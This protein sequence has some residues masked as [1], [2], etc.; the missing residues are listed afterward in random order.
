MILKSYDLKN[1]LKKKV[2]LY[3]L[4]GQN[5]DLINEVIEKNLKPLTSKNQY[6]YEES[7]ILLNKENFEESLTSKSFFEEDKLLIINRATDKILEIV[8]QIYKNQDDDLKIILKSGVL[9]KKSKLRIFFE[10][11]KDIIVIPFYED[12]KQSLQFIAQNFVREYNI[13]ISPQNINFIVEKSKGSRISLKSELEKIK[14][15]SKGKK[16]VEF[17]D[18]LKLTCSAKD[19]EISELADECLAKNKK[20]TISMLNEFNASIE[21]NILILKSFLYKLKRLKRLKEDMEPNK[22]QDQVL[23]SFKPPIFWKDKE[24][25]RKQLNTL[26]IND[27]KIFIKK[28]SELELL[29][30]KNSILSNEITNNFI[31]ET[32]ESSNNL[33]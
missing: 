31:F 23:S 3:L 16:S 8:E 18:L 24:I 13:K 4:Y 2:N 5:T 7:E 22:T 32:L 12:T 33:I 15:F 25:I 20:K 17:N 1:I 26:S 14:N 11:T 21:D 29:V 28:V 27:I 19:Y 30:K 9:E 10:K 6:N